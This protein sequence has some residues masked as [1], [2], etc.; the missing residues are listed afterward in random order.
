MKKSTTY[1]DPL[2]SQLGQGW[3]L[4]ASFL[5]GPTTYNVSDESSPIKFYNN[6]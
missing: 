4:T 6:N 3:T 5:L 1:G 2:V